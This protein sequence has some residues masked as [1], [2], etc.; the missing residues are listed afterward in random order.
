MDL[1]CGILMW[2]NSF[3][4]PFIYAVHIF[5]VSIC[6][7]SSKYMYKKLKKNIKAIKSALVPYILHCEIAFSCNSIS[8][9]TALVV[10]FELYVHCTCL[11]D[12]LLK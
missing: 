10:C 4:G 6:S 2:G 11:S 3:N 7:Q 5:L 12:S 1:A 9:T 8:Y